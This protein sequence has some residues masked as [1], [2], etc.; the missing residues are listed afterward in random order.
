MQKTTGIVAEVAIHSQE[1]T[2][3]QEPKKIFS[4]FPRSKNSRNVNSIYK[5]IIHEQYIYIKTCLF[6]KMS[7]TW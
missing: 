2:R 5:S 3:K 7:F 4:I 6:D 1:I